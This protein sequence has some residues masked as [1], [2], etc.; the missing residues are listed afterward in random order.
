MKRCEF[1]TLFGGAAAWPLA[2]ELGEILYS[3]LGWL[4]ARD[5]AL[6]RRRLVS[7]ADDTTLK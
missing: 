6:G 1:S 2:I 7:L 4:G 5:F 3:I